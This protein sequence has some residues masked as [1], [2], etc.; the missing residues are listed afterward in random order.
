MRGGINQIF[1]RARVRVYGAVIQSMTADRR[2][3]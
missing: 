2:R 3:F 1:F